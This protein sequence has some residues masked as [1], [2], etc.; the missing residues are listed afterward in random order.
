MARTYITLEGDVLD[1]I[2]WHEYGDESRFVDVLEANPDLAQY[3]PVL[4][5]GLRVVLPD[6]GPRVEAVK[7]VSLWD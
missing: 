6:F 2:C 3:H 4:P 1:R 7:A 5:A